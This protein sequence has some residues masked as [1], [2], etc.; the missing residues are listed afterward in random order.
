MLCSHRSLGM[1]EGFATSGNIH[2]HVTTHKSYRKAT[3]K[4]VYYTSQCMGHTP[5]VMLLGV[6][7][8]DQVDRTAYGSRQAVSKP[9]GW[10]LTLWVKRI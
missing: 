4:S 10:R 1:F 6:I 7:L 3:V 5:L 9:V 8:R 2:I